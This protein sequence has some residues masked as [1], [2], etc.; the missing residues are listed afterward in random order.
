MTINGLNPDGS[1]NI[2]IPGTGPDGEGGHVV[3][4]TPAPRRLPLEHRV[5]Q[6]FEH[7]F[8]QLG[9]VSVRWFDFAR[10]VYVIDRGGV[11]V[12]VDERDCVID[13]GPRTKRSGRWISD[14]VLSQVLPY[15]Y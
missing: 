2:F 11:R 4:M 9:T 6:T 14:L 3:H 5:A 12:E 1:I 15:G 13:E 10:R 8:P 7:L